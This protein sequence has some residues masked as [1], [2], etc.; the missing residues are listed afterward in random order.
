MV[1]HNSEDYHHEA[2]NPV[3]FDELVVLDSVGR[4][5]IPRQYLE[6]LNIGDRVRLELKNGIVAIH[7]VAGH[8]RVS[9][10]MLTT[11]TPQALYVDEEDEAPALKER[12]L[13][14]CVR[15]IVQRIRSLS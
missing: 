4:L 2:N 12:S 15:W 6:M 14:T 11:A 13:S 8:E 7:P 10:P 3:E 1:G 9:S 5:Q